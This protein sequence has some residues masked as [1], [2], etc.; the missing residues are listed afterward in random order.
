VVVDGVLDADTVTVR[1]I[2]YEF[3]DD[4]VIA[5]TSHAKVDIV[6]NANNYLT[7]AQVAAN[8]YRAINNFDGALV[9]ANVNPAVNTVVYV[10][11]VQPGTG[12]NAWTITEAVTDV[13]F[14]VVDIANGTDGYNVKGGTILYAQG[15]DVGNGATGTNIVTST[16]AA[17]GYVLTVQNTAS[18]AATNDADGLSNGV[19]EIP[20]WAGTYGYG[21]LA[22]SQSAR[23][24]DGTATIVEAVFQGDGVGDLPGT[25][26]TA[27]VTL[28]QLT[29]GDVTPATTAGDNIAVEYNIRIGIDQAAGLYTDTVTY[30]LTSTF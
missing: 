9:R 20:Q 29:P 1:G 8:L 26:S 11:A 2:V 12:P 7:A 17:G 24:G 19:V 15:V 30:I 10:M 28:A 18:N 21:I 13:N 25:M 23:Y 16:N 4:G 14:T 5:A 22:S 3:S 6:D 27:A